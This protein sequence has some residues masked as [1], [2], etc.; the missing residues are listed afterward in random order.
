MCFPACPGRS[1]NVD[2][3]PNENLE[4]LGGNCDLGIAKGGCAFPHVPDDPK[5]STW[6]QM[7][8]LKDLE[9]IV[10]WVLRD[11]LQA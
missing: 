7:R 6:N 10:I 2:L 11:E 1:E 9:E 3:E 8:T 4:G 5:M